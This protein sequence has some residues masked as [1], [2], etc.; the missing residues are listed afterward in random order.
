MHFIQGEQDED[1]RIGGD[2]RRKPR[3]Q[4]LG[5]HAQ[6]TVAPLRWE[7]FGLRLQVVNTVVTWNGTSLQLGA[8]CLEFMANTYYI[9]TDIPRTGPWLVPYKTKRL[10][11]FDE[12]FCIQTFGDLLPQSPPPNIQPVMWLSGGFW[13]F[14]EQQSV[15][16]GG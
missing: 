9:H 4:L 12:L 5:S 13:V 15:T 3:V 1:A 16:P 11:H 10:E 2:G 14:A 8:H 7:D 6:D